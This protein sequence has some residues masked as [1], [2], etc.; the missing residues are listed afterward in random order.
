MKLIIKNGIVVTHN[1]EVRRDVLVENGLITA[2]GAGLD[3]DADEVVDAKGC[4]VLPGLVDAHCHLRDPGYEYKEDIVSG[5][6]SA[7]LGGF[8]SVACMANT[9]PVAD[10]KAVI[11][12]IVDK[13]TREGYVN[14]FPIGAMTKGQSGEELAEIGEMK[15]AGIV[16]VSDDGYSV[17][18][19]SVMR[20][21]MLY[22]KMFDVAVLC[23]C[24][25]LDLAEEGVMNEG[26]LSTEMGLRGISKACEEIM[27][28]R[29]IILSERTQVPV[30][31]C[32]V[33]TA[34]GVDLIRKA[35]ERGVKVTA[36]TCPH[37]FTLTENACE[38]YNTM[39]KVNPPLRK[40]E[41]VEAIINGLCDG[42]IDI[43]ATDHAPHHAD[44]KNVEFDKAANGIVGFETAL[45]LSYTAL[46]ATGK[47]TMPEL[48]QTLCKGP[49][50][51]LRINR[52]ELKAGSAADI[53]IFDPSPS[54]RIDVEKFASKSKNS[55]FHG[56]PVNG[57][58]NFTIVGGKITVR[59]GKI[60]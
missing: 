44:E 27:I 40:S 54:Y 46:V 45:P 43:I 28:A 47:L 5:T 14:V 1:K 55:P 53:T 57:R 2:V 42:T 59:N 7:A 33:S 23:H 34:L 30:H 9:N 20:K 52:G 16:G 15:E 39:A 25:D 13:A 58:V 22:A 31:I 18:N 12:Y 11:R 26:C 56:Y 38:G 3:T 19:S 36:E 8:T 17:K 32:H 21:V 48:V 41:D 4:Y 29:D 24:E 60:V 50:D 51:I 37:Y 6:K 10:N 49:S 35:K